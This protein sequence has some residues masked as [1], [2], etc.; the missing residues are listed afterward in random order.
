MKITQAEINATLWRAC[1]TF[2][3]VIDPS[4]YKNYLL[5]MLFVK[6][7]SDVWQARRDE[8]M[9]KYGDN[10]DMVDRQLSRE[11]F[12]MPDGCAFED[13]FRQRNADNIGE[14][15]DIALE[16]IE[17]QNRTKLEGVFR[18]IS[19]NS[20]NLGETKDRNRR[21]KNLLEEFAN[22]RLDLRPS[23]VSEDIVGNAYM[24]LIENFA[25]DSG[26]KGGE[27][28]TPTGVSVLLAKL[29]RPKSGDRISDPTCGSGS[30][31]L[32]IAG[33][34]PEQ[35]RHNYSLFGQESNGSTW[36]LC[37]MNM[38]LHDEDSAQIKWGDTIN[39][40][41]LI[42][43]DR[44][45]KFNIV[46]A[47]PPFSLDKWGAESAAGD[48]HR[49][50]WRGTPPKS[51]ADYA[52]ISHMIETAL[53]LE[54]RV[55][56]IVP[57]GV[58]FRGAGEGKIRQQLLE[59]NLLDAVIGL[60]SNLFFGTGIP[61]A[62]LVFDRAR[63]PGGLHADRAEV[64]FVDG[65]RGFQPGKNGNALRL[66]DITAIADAYHARA[67]IA[68]YS[69]PVPVAEITANDFN[70]NIARYIDTFEAPETVDV[71]ALQVEIRTLE[72]D[73]AA[74]RAKLDGH[75]RQLEVIV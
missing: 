59:E 16:Q 71:T 20:D 52:F 74:V 10:A 60:P 75:L 38:V 57:H 66:D 31:L 72:T 63:E 50:F 70:L 13:L 51:K 49:R 40:P 55:A 11:R 21:L 62:I 35:E 68:R 32:R 37:R 7:I 18:N 27:F 45:L 26:K 33:E 29:L 56:V 6:Y 17:D 48:K 19:F 44:L 42:E 58:L 46:T 12:R 73:L 36:A 24:Y 2:R 15:I 53:P 9:Q 14:I 43:N 3:G 65:S 22:P 47:N 39:N 64:L 5:V 23:A 30:L 1:D 67:E 28:Y 25:S 8:L 54:G 41:L 4:D 61:A 69:R 34:I